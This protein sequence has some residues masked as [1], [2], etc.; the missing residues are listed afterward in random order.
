MTTARFHPSYM[1]QAAIAV[2]ASFAIHVA[3]LSG[4]THLTRPPIPIPDMTIWP[5]ILGEV[6]SFPAEPWPDDASPLI[7]P[8][9]DRD[10]D[11]SHCAMPKYPDTARGH[12]LEGVVG[13]F[14]RTD[15]TGRVTQAYV[16]S[17]SGY[18]VLDAAALS[19][20]RACSFRPFVRRGQPVA[21]RRMMAYEFGRDH[22]GL[23]QPPQRYVTVISL[24]EPLCCLSVFDRD[25]FTSLYHRFPVQ[26]PR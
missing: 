7:L 24:P 12:R 21:A 5:A 8:T 13:L 17:S 23:Y 25:Y 9:T 22:S 16:G 11:W 1:P 2:T 10:I 3:L 6:I 20:F 18:D 19:A 26:P 14:L 15:E 4:V